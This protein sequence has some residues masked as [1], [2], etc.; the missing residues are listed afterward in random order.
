M[1]NGMASFIIPRLVKENL[2]N[3]SIQMKSLLGSQDTWD[4]I[5]NDYTESEGINVLINAQKDALKDLRKKDKKTL[6]FIYQG[7]DESAF[8]RKT[9]AT[10]SKQAWRYFKTPIKEQRG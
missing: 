9:K 3:W 1:A 7:V 5:E 6:F 10:T 8:K 2:E 4:V